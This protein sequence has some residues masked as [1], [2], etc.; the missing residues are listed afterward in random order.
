MGAVAGGEL[1]RAVSGAGGLGLIGPGYH[2]ARWID[3]EF[4]VA[5]GARV[6]I[7]FIT[8]DLAQDPSK[9]SAALA[10]RPFAVLLSF[11]D[12]SPFVASIRDAG[13]RLILQVQTLAAAR[14]AARLAPDLIVA[15]GTEAGGHGGDRPLI[16][17]LPAVV[18]AVRP[19][20]VAAA[21][22]I[23]DGSGLAAALAL[24]AADALIG[25]RF[26]ATS[27]ALGAPEA[28]R[29][30]VTSGADSTVRTRIFD[31]VRRLAWPSEFSGRALRNAFTDHWHGRERELEQHLEAEYERYRVAALAAD[32][33]T[34][35]VW[36][37]EGVELID[38]VVPAEAVVTRLV[39]EAETALKAAR[40][41]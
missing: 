4:R 38:A 27:E 3:R 1:A 15:Q 23:A 37:G 41:P 33:A 35:V 31:I 25:T 12:A 39:R 13:A 2:D 8:W 10:H 21:G 24:G 14:D 40:A 7:G 30:L 20:P 34:S 36:A 16:S 17:L 26:F 28:K 32:P 29:L 6:G 9:L 11:G 22:G 18:D 19:L 5:Q